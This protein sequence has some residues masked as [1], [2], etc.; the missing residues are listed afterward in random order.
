MRGA[1]ATGKHASILGMGSEEALVYI[2][3]IETAISKCPDDEIVDFDGLMRGLASHSNVN[4]DDY[5]SLQSIPA[6]QLREWLADARLS[7]R[8]GLILVPGPWAG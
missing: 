4:V 6:G 2:H 3:A 8:T 7:I 1:W 5:P